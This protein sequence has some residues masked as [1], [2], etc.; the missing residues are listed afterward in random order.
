MRRINVGVHFIFWVLILTFYYPIQGTSA[1]DNPSGYTDEI[2]K[3]PPANS[4]FEKVILAEIA[5]RTAIEGRTD[6]SDAFKDL[7]GDGVISDADK[8]SYA[9]MDINADGVVDVLDLMGTPRGDEPA[10]IKDDDG[11]VTELAYTDGSTV[12]L[13]YQTDGEKN[14]TQFDMVYNTTDGQS[15]SLSFEPFGASPPADKP[16]GVLPPADGELPLGTLSPAGNLDGSGSGSANTDSMLANPTILGKL[17][18]RGIKVDDGK[19]FWKVTI[20]YPVKPF[21]IAPGTGRNSDPGRVVTLIIHKGK[22]KT[23]DDLARAMT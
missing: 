11:R 22:G 7:D 8:D 15:M 16:F 5:R 14:L 3:L 21:E 1:E 6:R 4:D 13:S 12:R 2:K 23:L 17:L 9:K 18:T 10:V 20:K 19:G